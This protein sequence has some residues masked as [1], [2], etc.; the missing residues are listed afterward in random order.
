MSRTFLH[1]GRKVDFDLWALPD[2]DFTIDFDLVALYA[3]TG[4]W[5]YVPKEYLSQETR[6]TV[7]EHIQDQD[8]SWAGIIVGLT[9]VVVVNVVGATLVAA[10]TYFA[11]PLLVSMGSGLLALPDLLVYK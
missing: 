8:N 9:A 2:F 7:E 11:N 6:E 3:I 4:V 10:G 1:K 5:R